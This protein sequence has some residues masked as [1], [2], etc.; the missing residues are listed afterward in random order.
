MIFTGNYEED[1]IKLMHFLDKESVT[2]E[3]LDEYQVMGLIDIIGTVSRIMIT[4][5]NIMGFHP[6]IISLR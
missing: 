6:V 4:S 1:K 5:L 3:E 2:L